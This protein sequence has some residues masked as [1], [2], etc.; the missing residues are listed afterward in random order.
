MLVEHGAVRHDADGWRL[1]DPEAVHEV[2]A[3]IRLV[4]AA[5]LDGLPADQKRVLHDASVCGAV[6][7]GSLLETLSDVPDP[8]ASLRELV[9]R[10]LLR[11]RPRSSIPG[12]TEYEWKHALIRDVAY[13]SL[14]RAVR[15]QRHEQVAAWLR[16]SAPAGRE[17][18]VAI[19]YHYERAWELE[20]RPN[21][22]GAERGDR[23]PRRRV[24]DPCGRAGV[25]PPGSGRRTAVPARAADHRREP[26]RGRPRGGGP[27]LDRSGRGSDRDGCT[28]RGDRAGAA[29]PEAGGACRRRPVGRSAHCSPSEGPKATTVGW[30]GLERCW[31]TRASGSSTRVTCEARGGRC[32]G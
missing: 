20:P 18:V 11:K 3:S 28:R 30:G 16:A 17:P 14:P 32:I 27:R 2:P 29:R 21:R 4:I 10:E 15:A 31:R 5:R 7:W 8:R 23:G 12:T 13:D 26:P 19:A 22:P 1:T 25:R 24:P 6:V 9:R